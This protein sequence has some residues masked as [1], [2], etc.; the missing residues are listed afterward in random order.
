ME[1]QV[2]QEPVHVGEGC[3]PGKDGGKTRWRFKA[4]S[5]ANDDHHEHSEELAFFLKA[6]N[7][8]MAAKC[9]HDLSES[10]VSDVLNIIMHL[11]RHVP[12]LDLPEISTFREMVLFLEEHGWDFSSEIEYEACKKCFKVYRGLEEVQHPAESCS[13]CGTPRTQHIKFY[14]RYYF[15]LLMY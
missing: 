1:P 3:Y 2:Q 7:S 13:S 6:V 4:R 12:G 10:A 11:S 8:L 14:Y 15:V 9:Q 5:K